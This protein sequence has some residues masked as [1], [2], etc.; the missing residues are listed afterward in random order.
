MYQRFL[1]H[2]KCCTYYPYLSLSIVAW[3][4]RVGPKINRI[5]PLCNSPLIKSTYFHNAFRPFRLYLCEQNPNRRP[6]GMLTILHPS[7]IPGQ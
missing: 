7:V 6:D 1:D 5:K 4:M 3:L 2:E